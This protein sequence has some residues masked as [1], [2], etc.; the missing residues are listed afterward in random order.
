MCYN[1]SMKNILENLINIIQNLLNIIQNLWKNH[2]KNPWI[3]SIVSPFVV[4]FLYTR[5]KKLWSITFINKKSKKYNTEEFFWFPSQIDQTKININKSKSHLIYG[6]HGSGKTTFAKIVM[7]NLLD[8]YNIVLVEAIDY[9]KTGIEEVLLKKFYASKAIKFLSKHKIKKII[10]R[11]KTPSM[12]LSPSNDIQQEIKK[13]L[14]NIKVKKNKRILIVIDEIDRIDPKLALNIINLVTILCNVEESNPHKKE[15]FNNIKILYIFNKEFIE[16][17]L[18]KIGFA[19]GNPQSSKRFW[20]KYI[21]TEEEI[22]PLRLKDFYNSFGIK[23]SNKKFDSIFFHNGVDLRQFKYDDYFNKKNVEIINKFPDWFKW[24]FCSAILNEGETMIEH[25]RIHILRNGFINE[26]L[27]PRIE[28]LQK[29]SDNIISKYIK[30]F[31]TKKK[32]FKNII[33][34]DNEYN[35]ITKEISTNLKNNFKNI[36]KQIRE[37]LLAHKFRN[38]IKFNVYKINA[39]ND[40]INISLLGKN[41][42]RKLLKYNYIK[43]SQIGISKINK[44]LYEICDNWRLN[45]ILKRKKYFIQEIENYSNNESKEYKYLISENL[46]NEIIKYTKSLKKNYKNNKVAK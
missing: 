45:T 12:F 10:K 17:H 29:D 6:L 33:T 7:D 19:I 16:N 9:Q 31:P 3:I 22:K 27:G 13:T 28:K 26:E 41:I 21:H 38:N 37:C 24:M 32:S 11:T 35:A 8:E 43:Y 14:K 30:T 36:K 34:L 15:K 4:Y 20:K 2:S 5:W 46:A 25:Q 39:L 44:I 1:I 23:F 18:L 42:N 40:L